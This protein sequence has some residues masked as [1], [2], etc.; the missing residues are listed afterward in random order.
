MSEHAPEPR[1]EERAGFRA[2]GMETRFV[3]ALSPDS[4]AAEDIGGLWQRFGPLAHG[5]PGRT[6]DVCYGLIFSPPEEDRG[7]PDELLYIACTPAA[8]G[9]PV[10]DGMAEHRV[11]AATWATVTHRGPIGNIAST[12]RALYR[13]WLPH[14]RWKHSGAADL[15]LYDERF[16]VDGPG[17]ATSEMEYSIS[18]APRD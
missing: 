2:V 4:T 16:C 18:V 9:S 13:D 8:E 17:Q 1:I 14:S 12:V 11:P 10:P 7:H 6:A 5:V 15:E 3:H